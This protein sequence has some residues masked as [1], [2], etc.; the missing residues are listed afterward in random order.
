[1]NHAQIELS[2]IVILNMCIRIHGLDLCVSV[3]LRACPCGYTSV[4]V[5]THAASGVFGRGATN[6]NQVYSDYQD[7]Q[8]RRI[9]KRGTHVTHAFLCVSALVREELRFVSS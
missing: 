4:S 7:L 5:Y 3:N 8:K 1:M 6:A 2:V 9:T